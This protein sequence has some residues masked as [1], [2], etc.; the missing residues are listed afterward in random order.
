MRILHINK[1]FDRR[2][3]VDIYL[4][5]LMRYQTEAGHETHVLATRAPQNV[6]SQ[7]ESYFI[8]RF[9]FSRSEGWKQDLRKAGAFLWNK[10]ARRATERILNDVKPDAIH[11]HNI[12]HHFSTSI[13]TPI[14][15]SGIR[16]V[17]TLHDYKL[18][19]PNYSMFTEG[20]VCQRCKGGRYTHAIRHHC[21]AP[22]FFANA[23]ATA[24]MTMAKAMQ[25]YERTVHRFLAPS[26]FMRD[27]MVEWGEPA[28]KFDI[29][30]N[31][32]DLPA[33]PAPS[34]GGYVL[35]VGRLAVTKGF[36]TLIRAAVRVPTLP[37]RIAGTGPDEERLKSIAR[38]IGAT[39]VTFLGFVPSDELREIRMRADAVAVPSVW[40]ENSPLAILE[41]MGEG[42]P[43]IASVIGGIPEL[44]SDG[45]NGLLAAP[46]D[47]EAWATAL[48]RFMALSPEERRIMGGIGRTRIAKRHLWPDHIRRLEEI[49]RGKD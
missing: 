15:A 1:F 7:D 44:V 6:P 16:C 36:E 48:R 35:G 21:L 29:V 49:Y 47:V 39:N 5:R 28:S 40:Y 9:D 32:A 26:Q 20:K 37:I 19:C 22:S 24:E 23:L 33:S 13:L 11:L 4:H 3:G 8:H 30:P 42:L 27:I 31:P 14:R 12:Y 18:A 41:A 34:G 46:G 43:V 45:E 25:S 10:E 17:Q 38:S 2:D